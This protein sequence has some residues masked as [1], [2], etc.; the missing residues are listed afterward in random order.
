MTDPS[1]LEMQPAERQA[2]LERLAVTL[3]RTRH[4]RRSRETTPSKW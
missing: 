4:G 1:F 3:A 2:V